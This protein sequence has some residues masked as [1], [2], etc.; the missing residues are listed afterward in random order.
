M[1]AGVGAQVSLDLGG[2]VDE[3]AEP[4]A[5]TGTVTALEAGDA[6]VRIAN[7]SVVVT[8]GRTPFHREADSTALGLDVRDGTDVVVVKIGYLEP[9]LHDMAADWLLALTPGGVDQDLL[10]LGHHRVERPLYP[11][12]EDAYDDADGPGLTPAQLA[13]LA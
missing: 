1:R 7:V 11:F 13:P 2:H 8:A 4:L 9:E 6:V 3:C 10:R 5:V 12:D